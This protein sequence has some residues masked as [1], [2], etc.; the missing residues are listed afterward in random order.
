MRHSSGGTEMNGSKS[1]RK[2][3]I[4]VR[5]GRVVL[6]TALMTGAF[7][8][9]TLVVYALPNH[10][11]TRQVLADTG[12]TPTPV[13]TPTTT[14]TPEPTVAPTVAPTCVPTTAPTGVP[15]PQ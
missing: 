2:R 9:G 13:A 15:P 10:P 3:S 6:A 12:P 5:H 1:T 14:P 7:L 8:S 4:L 11:G